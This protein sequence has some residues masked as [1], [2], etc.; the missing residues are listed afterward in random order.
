MKGGGQGG[1]DAS[2]NFDTLPSS[3]SQIFEWQNLAAGH[4]YG[5]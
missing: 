3:I 1:R 2:L 4:L 5:M